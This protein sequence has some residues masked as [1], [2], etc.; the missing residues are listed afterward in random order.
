MA[1][2]WRPEWLKC[3]P[4]NDS[5]HYNPKLQYIGGSCRRQGAAFAFFAKV[6]THL[7]TATVLC[8]LTTAI[9]Q[10]RTVAK[11]LPARTYVAGRCEGAIDARARQ[12]CAAHFWRSDSAACPCIRGIVAAGAPTAA[13]QRDRA[14]TSAGARRA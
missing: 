11:V 3:A 4:Q 12:F 2:G 10:S 14:G 6:V 8:G 9:T 13:E 7:F 5:R 1:E